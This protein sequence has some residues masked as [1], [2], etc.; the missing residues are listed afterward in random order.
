MNQSGNNLVDIRWRSLLKCDREKVTTPLEETKRIGEAKKLL[1]SIFGCTYQEA[2]CT[3]VNNGDST[4]YL[5]NNSH[6]LKDLIVPEPS[7]EALLAFKDRHLISDA[8]WGDVVDTFNLSC[9]YKYN[10]IAKELTSQHN[11][12]PTP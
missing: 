2:L 4:Q 11:N 5:L 8:A 10:V 1:Q 9:K 3:L 12:P 6:L 7:K